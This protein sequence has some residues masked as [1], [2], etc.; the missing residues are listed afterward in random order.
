MSR[1]NLYILLIFLI[2]ILVLTNYSFFDKK[3]EE[4]LIEKKEAFVE[5][6]I[7]GD[8]IVIENKTSVRLLGI[9]S[10][11]KGELYYEEAKKFLEDFVLDEKVYL[12]FD[13]KKYDKYNRILA[14][15]FFGNKNV[16]IE[17]VKKGFANVYI[18][19][20]KKYKKQL[21]EAW[22]DCI[23]NNKNLCEN[24]ENICA[25]CIVIDS[26]EIINKCNFNCNISDWQIKGEGRNKFIF[27][28][29]ILSPEQRTEFE[30]DLNNSGKDLF[31]RDDE[32]KLIL[33]D[34]LEKP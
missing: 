25:S 6:V 8:T 16:N 31:L 19:D 10:P 26:N 11:E 27:S 22:K 12:E 18:L 34:N 21:R 24:S 15:V 20:N 28:E 33:W 13:I 14:F 29:Q 7:D 4:F 3:I 1:K 32:G 23:K 17:L 5:R 30:L 9:N 2:F